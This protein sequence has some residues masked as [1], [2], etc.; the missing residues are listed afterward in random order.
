MEGTCVTTT[1]LDVA[2]AEN[3]E[4][5]IPMKSKEEELFILLQELEVLMEQSKFSIHKYKREEVLH[6]IEI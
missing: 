6:K 2:N 3:M 1:S 5:A 4:V